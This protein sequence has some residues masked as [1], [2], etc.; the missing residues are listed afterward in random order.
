MTPR[1]Y[2]LRRTTWHTQVRR[3]RTSQVYSKLP[4]CTLTISRQGSYRC[5]YLLLN[6]RAHSSREERAS[7]R[8]RI[9]LGSLQMT[10]KTVQVAISDCRLIANV[11]PQVLQNLKRVMGAIVITFPTVLVSKSRAKQKVK[12]RKENHLPWICV[13]RES[14]VTPQMEATSQ[15][16]QA[17]RKSL[18][19]GNLVQWPSFGGSQRSHSK[20][21][22]MKVMTYHLSPRCLQCQFLRVRGH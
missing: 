7:E 2:L 22:M 15:H 14:L 19:K 3:T 21:A 12:P 18:V 8:R 11:L 10:L 4:T 1:L 13:P 6:C 17:N 9:R 20:S 5:P 16:R